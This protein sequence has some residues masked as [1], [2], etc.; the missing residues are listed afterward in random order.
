MRDQSNV[1]ACSACINGDLSSSCLTI[2][3]LNIGKSPFYN[4]ATT[5]NQLKENGIVGNLVANEKDTDNAMNTCDFNQ[6]KKLFLGGQV[7]NYIT[8]L[9]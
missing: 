5:A 6:Y 3:I 2:K 8:S 7:L 9:D 1:C 4:L